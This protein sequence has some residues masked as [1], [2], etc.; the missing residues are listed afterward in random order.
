M[1]TTLHSG[2][3]TRQIDMKTIIITTIA[4]IILMIGAQS[5][6]ALSEFQSGYRHGVADGKRDYVFFNC[7]TGKVRISPCLEPTTYIHEPGK[8]FAFHTTEFVD[9]YIHGWCLAHNGGG[10]EANDDPEP[11][12]V[13]FDC[14]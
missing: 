9:G 6:Y 4:V 10:I 5:A 1:I 14:D 12:L 11:T 7:D 2:L 8:G 3:Q 13:S